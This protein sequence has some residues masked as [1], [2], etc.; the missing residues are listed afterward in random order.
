MAQNQYCLTFIRANSAV[1]SGD[2]KPLQILQSPR[3]ETKSKI[4]QEVSGLKKKKGV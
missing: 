4:T 1:L 2:S 3:Y